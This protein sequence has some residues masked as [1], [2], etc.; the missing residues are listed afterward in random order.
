ML[1]GVPL[2]PPGD[3]F[4]SLE[5]FQLT[6]NELQNF[7]ALQCIFEGTAVRVFFATATPLMPL[8]LLLACCFLEFFSK[9]MGDSALK[10]GG[11]QLQNPP[12]VASQSL[13][14]RLFCSNCS[15]FRYL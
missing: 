4:L 1:I 10:R 5:A 13:M 11:Q 3:D 8:A 14:F 7:L 15:H 2:R 12:V 6:T 9:G